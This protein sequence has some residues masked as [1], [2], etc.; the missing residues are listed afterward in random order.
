M[1][2]T[3]CGDCFVRQSPQFVTAY[4]RFRR[5][6][7]ATD[8]VPTRASTSSTSMRIM[9]MVLLSAPDVE[10]PAYPLKR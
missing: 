9:R 7:I 1:V 2:Y 5:M 3:G 6:T 10:G 8:I 4:R